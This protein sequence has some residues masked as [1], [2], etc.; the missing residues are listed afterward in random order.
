MSVEL[1]SSIP[2]VVQE[3]RR[4]QKTAL[5]CF[6]FATAC[7]LHRRALSKGSPPLLHARVRWYDQ[8]VCMRVDAFCLQTQWHC[9]R[10][11][12]EQ[13]PPPLSCL[14]GNS[15]AIPR[16]RVGGMR[17]SCLV[18]FVVPAPFA[19]KRGG[20]HAQ[21]IGAR[22]SRQ[23]WASLPLPPP[24]LDCVCVEEEGGGWLQGGG[25]VVP[26]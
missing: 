20:C 10:A 6:F 18:R 17:V 7:C 22:Q 13:V 3:S 11:N 24:P 2:L 16:V 12:Q 1:S 8:P 19:Q 25:T 23:P 9:G 26:A 21:E 4:R 5:A 15:S 14:V